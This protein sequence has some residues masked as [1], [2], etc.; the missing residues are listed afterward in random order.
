MNSTTARHTTNQGGRKTNE[1]MAD[2]RR[3]LA[4]TQEKNLRKDR[5]LLPLETGPIYMMSGHLIKCP[6]CDS[7]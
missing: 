3:R 6:Q 2:G 5:Y 1:D 4:W 7:D